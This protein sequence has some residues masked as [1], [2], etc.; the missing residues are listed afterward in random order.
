VSRA[1]LLGIVCL[2]ALAGRAAGHPLDP[3][4][5]DVRELADGRAEVTW[6]TPVEGPGAT[7][8]APVLPT[9]CRVLTAP[10]AEPNRHGRAVRWTVDC[11]PRGLAGGRFGVANLERARTV[12]LL[13]VELATGRIFERALRP[14]EAFVT[15]PGR[16]GRFD[17]FADYAALGVE[18]I[19]TGPDHLL[20]VF[21]LILLVGTA[22][23]LVETITAFTVG[24]SITLT[25][26]VLG[27]AN[28]PS[29]L[30]ELVIALTVL[31]LGVELARPAPGPTLLRRLPWV[32]ALAFGLV[33]GLGFAGAL[34]EVGLPATEVPVALV[35]FNVGIEMGQLVFVLV[36]LVVRW[37]LRP[38]AARLPAWAHRLPAY[39]MCALA[40]FWCWE[41]AAAL[42]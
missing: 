23:L 37:A 8:L 42:W 18:H 16:P 2:G 28:V 27:W 22:W 3:A 35:A 40:A 26:A 17:V 19:L 39:A 32:M 36:V 5:L 7:L 9:R 13:R 11:G 24:H 12:A 21:G 38:L 31:V 41:R 10:V 33:H 30:A 15:L 14:R 20:F 29:G 6:R 1:V 25:L 4:L 34:R